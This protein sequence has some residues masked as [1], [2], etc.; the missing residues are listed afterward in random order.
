V[1]IVVSIRVLVKD[2]VMEF[3]EVE[4][5][6]TELVIDYPVKYTSLSQG[7][8]TFV[9]AHLYLKNVDYKQQIDFLKKSGRP[10]MLDNGA[11]EFGSSMP[12]RDYLKII[13]ELE[14]NY[15]V[16][17]D[18][19]MN[20]IQSEKMTMDF[21][22]M[23][24]EDI[25]TELMFVPQGNNAEEVIE[26]YNSMVDKMG[27]FFDVLAVAKHIG[28]WANRVS[29]T[30]ELMS[31]IYE[32]VKNVHFL[33]FWN[34]DELEQPKYGDWELQSIDTKYPVKSAYGEKF[35][36]QLDYYNTDKVLDLDAFQVEVA[37][38][39]DDLVNRGW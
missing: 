11:W 18:V 1:Y 7:D 5:N 21:M 29:F 25:D 28:S 33:G 4:F 15:A 12:P 2:V 23:Y 38:F 30:D 20:T 24:N 27:M 3:V 8:I 36:S 9:L 34:W 19:Y 14:P 22:E 31:Q 32:P 6:M 35:N 13:Q 37:S 16:I 39:Q 10:L 26:S 17:P